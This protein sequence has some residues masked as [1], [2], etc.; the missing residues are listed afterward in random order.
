MLIVWVLNFLENIYVKTVWDYIE[1]F[2][3]IQSNFTYL[4]VSIIY[5][6]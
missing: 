6:T 2:L 3:L 1:I 4:T 5:K